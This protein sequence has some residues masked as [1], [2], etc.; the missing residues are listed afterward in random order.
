MMTDSMDAATLRR[1]AMQCMAQA[2]DPRSTGDERDRLMRMRLALLDL[3]KE[4][5]WLEGRRPLEAAPQR[6]QQPE[7]PPLVRSP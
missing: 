3:A 7:E 5:D 6:E 2:E 4:H 1:W